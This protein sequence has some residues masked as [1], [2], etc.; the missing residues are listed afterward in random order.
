[1]R[2]TAW[3]L[4]EVLG[5]KYLA[6]LIESYLTGELM[7]PYNPDKYNHGFEKNFRVHKNWN[8]IGIG[9]HMELISM[10]I[11]SRKI[12]RLDGIFEGVCFVGNM[13][14][15]KRVIG[16]GIEYFSNGL[17]NAVRG[18]HIDIVRM[19]IAFCD[20]EINMNEWLNKHLIEEAASNGNHEMCKLLVDTGLMDREAIISF[21]GFHGSIEMLNL[22]QDI[23]MQEIMVA[24]NSAC[25]NPSAG[26]IARIMENMIPH[27]I[28]TA[29][30][31]LLPHAAC[32]GNS[33]VVDFL[34]EKKA[35]PDAGMN[36]A[37][38]YGQM[39]IITILIA[40]GAKECNCGKHL[41]KHTP[42]YC[43]SR[44][45]CECV[46]MDTIQCID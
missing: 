11:E 21:G 34:L 3:I 15:A 46:R 22:I 31:E 6:L 32:H 12:K 42:E 43:K 37:C 25:V 39:N 33:A 28:H 36:A 23:T 41:S 4:Q 20:G 29:L 40:A 16:L 45:I 2:A 19:I 26:S 27:Y 10:A 18:N 8:A 44:K 24:A 30:P 14:L 38:L 5:V 13:D 17:H 9:E 1:M 35:D 7:V